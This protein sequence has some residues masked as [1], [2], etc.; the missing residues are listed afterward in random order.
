MLFS[1]DYFI[2]PPF[3]N[4]AFQPLN[5]S[6]AVVNSDF[7]A[8]CN[9]FMLHAT[10]LTSFYI[11][12]KA[13]SQNLCLHMIIFS[14]C[15]KKRKKNVCLTWWPKNKSYRSMSLNLWDTLCKLRKYLGPIVLSMWLRWQL[16][17]WRASGDMV[18]L[19]RSSSRGTVMILF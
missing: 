10:S 17:Y 18:P 8:S 3:R 14:C 9:L 12:R 11:F 1:P 2:L 5:I 4:S 16:R 7:I 19:W 13:L 15:F 6:T